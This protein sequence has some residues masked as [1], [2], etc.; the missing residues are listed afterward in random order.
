LAILDA[1]ESKANE[2]D[3]IEVDT[4]RLKRTAEDLQTLKK[5]LRASPSSLSS[6]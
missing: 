4:P 5:K 2:V 3:D 1:D 6:D